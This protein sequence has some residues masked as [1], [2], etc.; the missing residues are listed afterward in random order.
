MV[1]VVQI[2]RNHAQFKALGNRACSVDYDCWIFKRCAG[3][4]NLRAYLDSALEMVE[5]E[6]S[7]KACRQCGGRLPAG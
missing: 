5:A 6:E 3:N 2:E 7:N 1:R 4:H